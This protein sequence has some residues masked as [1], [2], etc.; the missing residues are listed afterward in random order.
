MK[1]KTEITERV[2]ITKAMIGLCFMA[3]CAVKDATDEEIL[4]VCNSQNPAGTSQGWC[5]VVRE[6]NE[7]D[8]I[9][10]NMLPV[11]CAE[12]NKRMH[13]LVGC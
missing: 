2:V 9:T 1:K 5:F 8:Y 6:L 13:F 12:D 7:K 4:R 3:V 11:E 10:E